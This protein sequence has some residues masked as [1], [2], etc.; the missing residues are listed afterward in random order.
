MNTGWYKVIG[1]DLKGKML[2]INGRRN[3]FFEMSVNC[4]F[5]K[6]VFSLKHVK[7]KH[8]VATV[9]KNLLFPHTK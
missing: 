7:H 2:S 9:S 6:A 3:I 1:D 4:C 5:N 8:N